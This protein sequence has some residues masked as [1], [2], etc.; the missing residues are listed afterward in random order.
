MIHSGRT[1]SVEA[2]LRD[3]YSKEKPYADRE[4]IWGFH[5]EAVQRMLDSRETI[6]FRCFFVRYILAVHEEQIRS[7][8]GIDPYNKEWLDQGAEEILR[9]M[10]EYE[11][12]G[13]EESPGIIRLLTDLVFE[14]F[15]SNGFYVE[16]SGS[17]MIEKVRGCVNRGLPTRG[18]KGVRPVLWDKNELSKKIKAKKLMDDEWFAFAFGMNMD[19]DDIL[20]FMKKALRRSG[21][22]LWNWKEFLLYLTYKYADGNSFE[23][24]LKLKEAYEDEKNVPKKYEWRKS[25]NFST[26]VIEE[27]T[28][29]IVKLIKEENYTISLDEKGD[30]PE[31]IVGYLCNYKYLIKTSEDYNR[32]ISNIAEGLLKDF[33]KYLD[34]DE[35]A[36]KKAAGEDLD[37]TKYEKNAQGN[38]TIYYDPEFG[39]KV[40]KRTEFYKIDKKTGKRIT[41]LSEEDIDIEPCSVMNGCE[42]EIEIS[43]I[44][45]KK[46]KKKDSPEQQYGYVPKKSVFQSDNPYVTEMTNKSYF[47]TPTKVRVGEETQVAG[48]ITARCK[49]GK[50]IPAGTKFWYR[51][52]QGREIEFI[53]VK[54]VDA[55][56]YA[57]IWV[58]SN[59]AGQTAAKNE[60]VDCNISDWQKKFLRLENSKIGFKQKKEGQNA[61]GGVLYNYLYLPNTDDYRVV[62]VLDAGYADKLAQILEGTQLSSTKLCQ[63]ANRTEKNITRNDILTLS[64]LAYMSEVEERRL[65]DEGTASEDYEKRCSENG[66]MQRTNDILIKCGYHQLYAP[67][68]YDSLLMCLVSS[69]EA[70][71][72]FRNLWSWFLSRREKK[73]DKRAE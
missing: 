3:W 68:P 64:F 59:V 32:T 6:P 5:K 35:E 17:D 55:S 44:C 72:A 30:L 46:E 47:K 28:D 9:L 56:V 70:V 25:D 65:G 48:K 69:N 37:L 41:F 45:V 8:L 19:Y 31:K 60:I 24:Y 20:F 66:F 26:V 4:W 10:E 1:R 15:I 34:G 39:L 29:I 54:E 57:D 12:A 52:K 21:F 62:D 50:I 33:R 43:L 71:N 7:V 53:S 42:E 63:I 18:K 61:K 49:A 22:N 51:D 67:N 58:Y 38:V 11:E 73:S 27:Q 36:V 16:E 14:D 40:P 13:Y 23:F 2:Q